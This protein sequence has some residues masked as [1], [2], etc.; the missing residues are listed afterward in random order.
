M[1]PPYNSNYSENVAPRQSG[2]NMTYQ[3]PFRR[4]EAGGGIISAMGFSF[5]RDLQQEYGAG[6]ANIQ[7]HWT[8]QQQGYGAH[9]LNRQSTSQYYFADPSSSS[10]KPAEIV[11]T[12]ISAGDF[13]T[14][15]LEKL[16]GLIPSKEAL[17]KRGYKLEQMSKSQLEA[18]MKCVRCDKCGFLS[19]GWFVVC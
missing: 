17:Q 10:E 5:E 8:G 16:R 11:T 15:Y 4:G 6:Q 18:K 19:A 12:G 13:N 7:A 14:V 2:K 1:S 9:Q 3:P